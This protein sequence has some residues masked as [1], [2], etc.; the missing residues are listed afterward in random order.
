MPQLV[1]TYARRRLF[2][3]LDAAFGRDAIWIAAPAGAG[4]T[5]LVATYLDARRL[6]A[7]WYNVDARDQDIANLFHYLSMG[8]RAAAKGA[9]KRLPQFSVE[10]QAGVLAFARGFFEALGAARPV[11]SAIVIDD[12]HEARSDLFGDVVREALRVLPRGVALVVVSRSEPPADWSDALATGS[13]VTITWDDLRFTPPEIAGFV[14]VYRPDLRERERRAVLP[15]IVELA[16]GW[17]AALTLLLQTRHFVPIDLHGMEQFSERLFDYFAT[18]IF[19]KAETRERDFLLKTSVVPRFTQGLA[20]R[21]AG[22]EDAA[23]LLARLSRRSF[24]TQQLGTSGTY[25]HHPLLRGFLL[26]RA[27]ASLGEQ[28]M[29]ELH[30]CAARELVAADLVDEAI[31][32]LQAVDDTDSI[33]ALVLEFAPAYI[34]SGRGRTIE[35]WIARLPEE[36]ISEDGWL[37]Q[38]AG[39]SCLAH[40]PG[41]SRN[42]FERAYSRFSRDR[43]AAGLYSACIGGIQGV[44]FESI[45]NARCDVWID[46]CEALEEQAVPC[47]PPLLPMFATAR[48]IGAIF[49]RPEPPPRAV[50]PARAKQLSATSSDVAERVTAGGFLALYSTLHE[51]LRQAAVVLEMLRESARAAASS[52]IAALALLQSDAMYAWAEGNNAK[53]IDLVREAMGMAARTG[54]FVWDDHLSAIGLSATLV[55]GQFD[56]AREFLEL[57]RRSAD[58]GRIF[59]L[60]GYCFFS[61]WEAFLRGDLPRALEFAHRARKAADSYGFPLSRSIVEFAL[62]QISWQMGKK[63]EARAALAL[64]RERAETAGYALVL[65]ALDLVESDHEWDEDRDHALTCLRRGLERSRIGG[66]H[67]SFWLAQ[68]TMARAAV[69]ALDRGW[70]REHVRVCIA[71]HDLVPP[72]APLAPDGWRFRYRFRALGDFAVDGDDGAASRTQKDDPPPR[73]S[74]R[75]MPRNL[76]RAII[77]FGARGVHDADVIDALWPAQEGDAGRRVFDTT[78]HRLRRQLGADDVVRLVD[79]RIY[80]DER[81][82]WVDVWAMDRAIEEAERAVAASAPAFELET[83]AHHLLALYRGPLLV[84]D[85]AHWLHRPR[86]E[87]GARFRSAARRLAAA[88]EARGEKSTSVMLGRR[89]ETALSAE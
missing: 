81:C 39:V 49:R 2:R 54:V 16:G 15:Q 68:S 58:T 53:C 87:L 57:A 3:V 4:K 48:L 79:R 71:K 22:D 38:W 51:G 19:D 76:L 35:S 73:L 11:P 14:R 17:P 41:R 75:G 7:L 5:S 26:R 64:A 88:L 55:V 67:N 89:A 29:R 37:L 30:L 47:P 28:A 31:E 24:L 52:G 6:P 86:R 45:D 34:A 46:R 63:Q 83:S 59:A 33:A 82:C 77:A 43:D 84:C 66:Y 1:E 60:G 72:F 78:L 13:V 32:Q 80:L 61:S 40:T 65:F 74:P 8:A 23:A 69:R 50:W 10:N 42:F 12:Y 44:I 56:T 85:D 62:A 70:E 36:R 20:E 9:R 21:L 25:R 18:E 27:S